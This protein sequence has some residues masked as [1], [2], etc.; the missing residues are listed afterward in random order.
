MENKEFSIYIHIPFC[1]SKCNYCDFNSFS[2]CDELIDKYIEKLIED[3]QLSKYFSDENNI[4]KTIYIGGGTPSY[5]NEKYIKQILETIKNKYNID[6]DVEI[7]IECNPSSINE[8]KLKT[9]FDIGINRIS[10]GLQSTN[11]SILKIIGRKHT[12]EMFLEKYNLVR[13]IGFNN[14]NVDLMIGLPTQTLIDI[15]NDLEKVISLKPTHIS[16]YSLIIYENTKIYD[17]IYINK[18]SIPSD[19]EERSM[20]Y[21]LQDNLK[22]AGYNQYEISNFSKPGYESKHNTMC[23]KQ[24]EYIGFGAG[25]HSFIQ[26]KRMYFEE[27]INKYINSKK[28][29]IEEILSKKDLMKEYMII[30]FRMLDGINKKEFEIKFKEKVDEV[31]EEEIKKLSNLELISVTNNNI[32]LT[33]KGIDFANIVWEEFI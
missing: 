33:K 29:I 32:K 8:D 22:E 17:D 14:I 1:I 21:L 10:I 3:I 27:N 23:W 20:Y 4:C 16:S 6:K 12:F 7:T 31:F 13:K 15:K 28:M 18:Y 25:A 26:N 24:K 30:G 11:N 9:Y 5:I 2:N 19:E